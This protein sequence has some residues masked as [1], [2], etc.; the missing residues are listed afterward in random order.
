MLNESVARKVLE[1]VDVG[2]VTG[3]GGPVARLLASTS[4]SARGALA[5][6][7]GAAELADEGGVADVAEVA[8]ADGGLG[9]HVQVQVDDRVAGVDVEHEYHL[10]HLLARWPLFLLN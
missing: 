4:W 1:T 10:F 6:E 9:Q 3:V 2:L 7:A 8:D 5:V